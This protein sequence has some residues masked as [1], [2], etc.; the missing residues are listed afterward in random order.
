MNIAIDISPLS[1]GHKVRGTGFY[2]THVKEALLTYFPEHKY[3]FFQQGDMLPED[4]EIVHYP[5]FEPFSQTL[6]FKRKYKTVVTV[7]DLTPIVMKNEF[8]VGIKGKLYWQVQKHALKGIDAVITDSISSQHDIERI[9]GIPQRKIHVVYLAAGE[10]FKQITDKVLLSKIKEKYHLPDQFVLY[11]GDA[12]RNKNV[13]LLV[14]ACIEKN[15][16]LVLVGKS[17]SQ[18]DFDHNHPWNKDLATVERLVD[19]SSL[20]Q[21]LG[22]VS[23][24]D[25]VGIYNLA[26]TFVMPS[27]YEGFGLPVLEAMACGC[28]VISSSKSSLPEVAGDA[29]YYADMTSKQQLIEAIEN[30]LDNKKFQKELSLKGLEQSQK[31]SWKQTAQETVRVYKDILG[32]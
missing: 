15:I 19:S 31:F 4:I 30:V 9:V 29:A 2:L 16:P 23:D 6:P 26:T 12:T 1:T 28:P 18:K 32:K 21:V 20:V 5:Y 17:L 10:Y 22:F 24:E 13:P 14:N 7:H 3:T 27:L 25:L 11:V 8:P